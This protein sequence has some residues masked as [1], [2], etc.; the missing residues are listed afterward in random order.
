MLRTASAVPS[1]SATYS[2]T[3]LSPIVQKQERLVFQ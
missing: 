2:S 3:S 1:P